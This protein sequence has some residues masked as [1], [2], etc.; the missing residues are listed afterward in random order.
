[1]S[2]LVTGGAGLLG[3]SISFGYKPPKNELNLLNYKE[4]S[5]YILKNNI[6]EIIHAAGKVGGV[7]ANTKY[8]FDFFEDNLQINL[9][10]LKACKEFKLNNSTFFLST[11]IFP[12][13]ASLPLV[14]NMVHD[15]EP[16][17][18]NYGYAYAKR[19]LEVGSR[20][21]NQQY[22]IKTR[23]IIPCNMYGKNDNYNIEDGHV[24]PS[25]IHKCY[26]AKK[27]NTDFI[28]WGSGKAER[29]FLYA[30]DMARILKHIHVDKIEKISNLILIS[31]GNIY[32]IEQII[33]YIIKIMKF[34]GNVIFDKSKPEG[35][36]RKNTDNTTFKKYFND[37][38]FTDIENGLTETIEYFIRNYN[39]IRK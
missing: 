25:L 3:S 8:I 39:C 36:L 18:T 22:L 37:F 19:M 26:L 33:N 1:M 5:E 15:G 32:S 20:C 27:T 7:N 9:N 11:C 17:I 38:K 24:I 2:I 4:L 23:C 29:E 30:D 28:V 13:K 14:E 35:I 21:L 31:D 34:N 6:T 10:I 16:H 12:Y